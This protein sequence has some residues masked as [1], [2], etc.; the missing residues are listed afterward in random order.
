MFLT[1]ILYI[2]FKIHTYIG[3]YF[4]Y[5]L[6]VLY[7]YIIPFIYYTIETFNSLLIILDK[8]SSNISLIF[9]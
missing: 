7:S 6:F 5:I 9:D 2:Y 8:L 3:S 1:L 4:I